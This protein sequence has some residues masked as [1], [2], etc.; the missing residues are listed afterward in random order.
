MKINLRNDLKILSKLTKWTKT[1]QDRIET[2]LTQIKE[3]ES[4]KH[5][6][7][8][9]SQMIRSNQK[10]V[11]SLNYPTNASFM[12]KNI[13]DKQLINLNIENNS[14]YMENDNGTSEEKY[15]RNYYELILT[16]KSLSEYQTI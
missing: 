9:N 4:N 14:N 3:K 12:I 6:T 5:T 2:N 1:I 10:S 15:I 8:Y 13:I 11:S 7:S 16:G